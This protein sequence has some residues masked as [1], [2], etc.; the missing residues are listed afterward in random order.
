M[1]PLPN[2]KA[3][4]VP[5][6]FQAPDSCRSHVSIL[7]Q[8]TIRCRARELRFK[9]IEHQLKWGELLLFT[10]IDCISSEPTPTPDIAC[11]SGLTAQ[12]EEE[13]VDLETHS[14]DA[15]FPSLPRQTCSIGKC[16]T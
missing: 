4:Y 15:S 10:N 12:A 11:A 3:V 14:S 7:E 13:N 16:V 8:L 5:D 9:V 1:Q 2:A 6:G